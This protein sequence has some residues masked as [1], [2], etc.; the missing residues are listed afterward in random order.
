FWTL[1]VILPNGDADETRNACQLAVTITGDWSVPPVI[2]ALL[3]F[4]ETTLGCGPSD[5]PASFAVKVITS[6]DP[7]NPPPGM[8]NG[9]HCGVG[10][11]AAGC[12]R[13]PAF[14]PLITMLLVD[15]K[16]KP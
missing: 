4:P 3:L 15:S 10:L 7:L 11:P 9:P 8:M 13:D 14:C 1:P 5:A 6:V 16:P 2:W 12:N